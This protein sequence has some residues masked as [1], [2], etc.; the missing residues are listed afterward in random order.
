MPQLQV[1]PLPILMNRNPRKGYGRTKGGFKKGMN[2]VP[3]SGIGMQVAKN[4]RLDNGRWLKMKGNSFFQETADSTVV[5]LGSYQKSDGTF[6]VIKMVQIGSK[7]KFRAYESTTEIIP[8]VD[9]EFDS[10]IFGWDQIAITGYLSNKVDFSTNEEFFS[11]DGVTLT[12]IANGVYNQPQ[13]LASEGRRLV[14][15]AN[16]VVGFSGAGANP[17][18][19]IAAGSGADG[20]GEYRVNIPGIPIGVYATG[21][22]TLIAFNTGLELHNVNELDN[23]TGIFSETR[24]QFFNYQGSGVDN[25]DKVAVAPYYVY[26]VTEEGLIRVNGDNGKAKNLM[27]E[28]SGKIKEYW[29]TFDLENAKAVYSPKE[30]MVI[31]SVSTDATGKND[32]LVCYDEKTGAFSLKDGNFSTLGVVNRQL[33]GGSSYDGKVLR[34]FDENTYENGEGL[35]TSMRLISEWDSITEMMSAKIPIDLL[36]FINAQS[37]NVIT[38]NVYT[39]GNIGPQ[40]TFTFQVDD[41]KESGL[42]SVMGSYIMG[43]GQPDSPEGSDNVTK[44]SWSTKFTSW[45]WEF[46]EE[47]Q[48]P[49]IIHDVV[50][51]YSR[52][53]EVY[54]DTSYINQL[55]LL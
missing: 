45:C 55:F 30:E 4:A 27:D 32:I 44:E 16:G 52:L 50:L 40:A 9:V 8:T 38:L 20:P 26:L 34:I 2:T 22:G 13:A 5:K 49:V 48:D 1:K 41:I 28:K 17:I 19:D 25:P 31:I 33:Y 6:Q 36:T 51:E 3:F 54:Q 53:E 24:K 12:A 10:P 37:D 11:W 29:K 15:I 39:D 21:Y 14:F 42:I 47:S 46:V 7:W 35:D 23:G 43:I 18:I